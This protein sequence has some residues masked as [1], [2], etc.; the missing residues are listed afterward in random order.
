MSEYV[1]V[2]VEEVFPAVL[3]VEELP[4][5]G[6]EE[7]VWVFFEGVPPGFKA[8]TGDIDEEFFVFC[9]AAVFG[10]GRWREGVCGYGDPADRGGAGERQPGGDGRHGK[11]S[12]P[13]RRRYCPPRGAISSSPPRW[14]RCCQR[15]ESIQPNMFL[16]RFTTF[17]ETKKV[18][19]I[20]REYSWVLCMS[21]NGHVFFSL[22]F[23]NEQKRTNAANTAG[24]G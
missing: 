4:F 14:A 10:D 18:F 24:S 12:G 20:K 19:L 5:G 22:G 8:S 15:G 3:I 11:C 17:T 9:P 1:R 23:C 21:N 13:R 16:I 6:A 2:S 7:G